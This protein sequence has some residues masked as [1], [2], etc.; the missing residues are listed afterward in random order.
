MSATESETNGTSES[1]KR[2]DVSS[3]GA[4]PSVKK[5]ESGL[6]YEILR[7]GTG[8]TPGATDRVTVHYAGWLESGESFDS[9]FTGGKP[10]TFGVN[11]VIKGWTEGLQLM[12]EGAIYRFSI[13]SDLGYGETGSRPNIPPNTNLVFYVE[14]VKVN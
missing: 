1:P 3:T 6:E 8:K 7:K 4:T 11:R 10:S 14:L 2:S 13:P 12:K 9:S 5:T